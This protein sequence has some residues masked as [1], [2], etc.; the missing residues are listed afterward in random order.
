MSGS[1]CFSLC[2][3]QLTGST[4][5]NRIGRIRPLLNT[6]H[7]QVIWPSS[8]CRA[9]SRLDLIVSRRIEPGITRLQP[10]HGRGVIDHR[11]CFHSDPSLSFGVRGSRPSNPCRA[12][13]ILEPWGWRHGEGISAL[14]LADELFTRATYSSRRVADPVWPGFAQP[15][16]SGTTRAPQI[17][18]FL[19]R[20]L[21]I[22]ASTIATPCYTRIVR[23]AAAKADRIY[24]DSVSQA[25]STI[26][27][28][29]LRG[30]L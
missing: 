23:V 9:A 14:R 27:L 24:S 22:E 26:A 18:R 15:Q 3:A 21:P 30:S 6:A 19:I 8:R 13:R 11:A 17:V 28:R 4:P 16:R 12:H 5:K 1:K 10:R 7:G 25:P 29:D 20:L 2:G